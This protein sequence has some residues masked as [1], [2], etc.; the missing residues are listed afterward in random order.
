MGCADFYLNI[1]SDNN[2]VI[3]ICEKLSYYDEFNV[4]NYLKNEN[5]IEIE[6]YFDN[7]LITNK[8]LFSVLSSFN[9]DQ[10]KIV[11]ETMKKNKNFNFNSE[12]EMFNWLFNIYETKMNGYFKDYGF[13]SIP[14]KK[15]YKRRIKLKK[16]YKKLK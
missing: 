11:I 16:Y 12:L 15:Y 10:D 3:K 4:F 7:F 6:G 8:I 14:A 13:L 1:Y 9:V 5:K 2:L